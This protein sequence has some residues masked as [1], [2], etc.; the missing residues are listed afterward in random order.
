[1]TEN[2]HETLV[3]KENEERK[4]EDLAAT[5]DDGPISSGS[6]SGHGKQSRQ[7]W[8]S[9]DDIH[10][11]NDN[12]VAEIMKIVKEEVDRRIAELDKHAANDQRR[13]LR[14]RIHGDTPKDRQV[15]S[16]SSLIC[17]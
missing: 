8:K 5:A 6:T 7:A 9:I 2:E 13:K 3:S 10:D 11:P 15:L 12:S 14:G 16:S 1:M 4:L 17:S